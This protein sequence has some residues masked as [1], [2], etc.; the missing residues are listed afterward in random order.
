MG[1]AKALS[2]GMCCLNMDEDDEDLCE[3]IKSDYCGEGRTDV[4]FTMRDFCRYVGFDN[5]VLVGAAET[6][7][8]VSLEVADMYDMVVDGIEEELEES[9]DFSEDSSEDS[10]EGSSE[11]SSED[12]SEAFSREGSEY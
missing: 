4:H 8:T 6:A 5:A 1:S 10:S 7:Q 2:L 3:N 11:D 12:S 9:D